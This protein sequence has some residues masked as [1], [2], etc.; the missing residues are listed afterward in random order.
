MTTSLQAKKENERERVLIH[1][2]FH[3]FPSAEFRYISCTVL[4][5]DTTILQSRPTRWSTPCWENKCFQNRLG[6]TG[7]LSLTIMPENPCRL[8]TLFMKT[9]ATITAE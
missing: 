7:S 4:L 1:H 8:Y 9:V 3:I 6:N 5:D 2:N